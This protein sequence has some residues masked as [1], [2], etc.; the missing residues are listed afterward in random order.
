MGFAIFTALKNIFY[1]GT[2][3]NDIEDLNI[4]DTHNQFL[5]ISVLFR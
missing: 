1:S 4:F 5:E 3:S 2:V